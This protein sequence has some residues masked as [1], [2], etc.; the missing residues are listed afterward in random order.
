MQ[1]RSDY[2][3]RDFQRK[4]NSYNDR[5][6]YERN[7]RGGRKDRWREKSQK[8]SGSNRHNSS[9]EVIEVNYS[10]YGDNLEF[11]NTLENNDDDCFDVYK[12]G[13]DDIDPNIGIVDTACPKTCAGRK[14]LDCHVETL[15]VESNKMQ[16]RKRQL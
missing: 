3:R 14:W 8:R 4:G 12:E 13:N 1:S 2:N 7:Q 9:D 6:D 5:N 16:R 11:Q 10:S 15:D